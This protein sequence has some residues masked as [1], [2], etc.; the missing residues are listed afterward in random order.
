MHGPGAD[1]SIPRSG[2][3]PRASQDV[4]ELVFERSEGRVILPL[5]GDRGVDEA[6]RREV[7]FRT[8]SRPTRPVLGV[9]HTVLFNFWRWPPNLGF[10]CAPIQCSQPAAPPLAAASCASSISADAASGWRAHAAVPQHFGPLP[11]GGRSPR[12]HP[13]YQLPG[14]LGSSPLP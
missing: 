6:E 10:S 12:A 14:A 4:G 8:R 1:L 7:E 2:G 3:R 9:Q 11:G 13:G 5:Q